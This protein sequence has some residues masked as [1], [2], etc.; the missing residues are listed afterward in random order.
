MNLKLKNLALYYPQKRILTDINCNFS[1]GKPCLIVGKSGSGK[2]TLLKTL[3][4]FHDGYNG[5]I[6]LDDE[7]FNAAGNIS[8]AFQDPEKL[9][10]CST[11][12]DEVSYALKQKSFANIEKQASDWLEK[13]GL[14]SDIYAE[15]HPLKLSGGEKRKVAL[16]ACTVF[17]PPVI[18]LDEP[19]AGLD[20]NGQISVCEMIK[21]I[22]KDR[23]VIVVTHEPEMFLGYCNQILYIDGE[24]GKLL[25]SD[26][27][28]SYSV[29]KPDFYPLPEW[30]TKNVKDKPE[31]C[32]YPPVNYIDLYNF[33]EK[34]L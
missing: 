12:I 13:W 8:L 10:F 2:S 4:G 31:N 3:A 17:L 28:I 24:T 1:S 26:E 30:Y 21:S 20:E 19:L 29:N 23:I 16:A 5:E 9:F 27:F 6:F 32:K 34:T 11:V 25:D 22:S 15:R 7:S 18:L 14:S 33:L